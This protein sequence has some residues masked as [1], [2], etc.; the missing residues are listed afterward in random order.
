MLVIN[1]ILVSTATCLWSVLDNLDIFTLVYGT[2]MNIFHSI[3][4]LFLYSIKK[5]FCIASTIQY[6][7]SQTLSLDK[8]G[9]QESQSVTADTLCSELFAFVQS[10]CSLSRVASL[11][12][13]LKNRN[14]VI[15]KSTLN[16]LIVLRFHKNWTEVPTFSS[17]LIKI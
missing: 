5:S 11:R 12:N 6:L 9:P 17:S 3:H 4:A 13:N 7:Q 1:W 14:D 8:S 10:C 2:A 16:R 15:I